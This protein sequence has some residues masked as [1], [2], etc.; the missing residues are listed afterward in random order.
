MNMENLLAIGI[1]LFSLFLGAWLYSRK[2]ADKR[3]IRRASTY[4]E[5]I[6]GFESR[7]AVERL[8]RKSALNTKTTH[9]SGNVTK[10]PKTRMPKLSAMDSSQQS[11]LDRLTEPDTGSFPEELTLSTIDHG[12]YV[13]LVVDDSKVARNHAVRVL[14]HCFPDSEIITAVDGIDG[15]VKLE[16]KTPDLILSDID[17]PKVDGIEFKRRIR[18]DLRFA[19]LPVIL[20]SA[21]VA[22]YV[23][24][25]QDKPGLSGFLPKPYK[26]DDLIQQI[27]F[28]LDGGLF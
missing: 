7:K 27:E 18:N 28:L 21:H 3:R 24:N 5:P 22:H 26:Q 15:W 4:Q 1:V 17:M 10:Q 14:K 20:V 25:T 6:S 19:E 9:S 23:K 8:R 12:K 2:K 16:E 13:F 11:T